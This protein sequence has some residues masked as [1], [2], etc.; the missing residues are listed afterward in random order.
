MNAG[1]P[2][3]FRIPGSGSPRVPVLGAFPAPEILQGSAIRALSP[4]GPS[5]QANGRGGVPG[6]WPRLP[7]PA[8][9]LTGL[10]QTPG[11]QCFWLRS[12]KT[13]GHDTALRP[14][15]KQDWT[16][17]AKPACPQPPFLREGDRGVTPSLEREFLGGSPPPPT[18][19]PPVPIPD[20]S[21]LSL[22]GTPRGGRVWQTG[23]R[24]LF[25]AADLL[26][27][28]PVPSFPPREDAPG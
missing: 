17:P 14:R 8:H 22:Q 25:F 13:K 27:R 7:P 20:P 11:S 16:P 5:L 3:R 26:P 2:H 4:S 23:S 9:D 1:Q 18:L 15:S 10:S 24:P 21:G 6:V 28:G 12:W 19:S